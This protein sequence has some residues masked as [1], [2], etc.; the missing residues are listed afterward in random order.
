MRGRNEPREG[1]ARRTLCHRLK[2]ALLVYIA[3]FV[4]HVSKGTAFAQLVT[5]E[6]Y[7]AQYGQ[8]AQIDSALQGWYAY[9][10]N[11]NL[12][13]YLTANPDLGQR[14]RDDSSYKAQFDAWVYQTQVQGNAYIQQLQAQRTQLIGTMQAE[15]AAAQA[16]QNATA[17]ASDPTGGTNGA[18]SAGAATNSAPPPQGT[19]GGPCYNNHVELLGVCSGTTSG[20]AVK[21]Q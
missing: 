6:Q 4:V 14:Y 17:Q 1:T 15:V 10:T 3:T 11:E 18:P 5:Q 9:V 16:A 8:V 12:Y 21:P 20:A 13:S 19:S 2:I 7:Q